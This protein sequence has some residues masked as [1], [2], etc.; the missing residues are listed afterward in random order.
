MRGSTGPRSR[1][2]RDRDRE[3]EREKRI[4]DRTRHRHASR[5][6]HAARRT[7]RSSRD[8]GHVH[9]LK[10]RLHLR[11]LHLLLHLPLHCLLV[12]TAAA[13]CGAAAPVGRG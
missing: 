9:Y 7:L 5:T 12:S 10:E 2:E 4:R 13:G 11:H 1:E 8:V 3:R 6:P